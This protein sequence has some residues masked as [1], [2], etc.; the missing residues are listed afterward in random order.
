MDNKKNEVFF[1]TKKLTKKF[2]EV[3]AVNQV[4][5][6]IRTGEIRGLIGENGSGKSTIS[7]MISAIHT[8]TDGEMLLYGKPYKPK[9]PG[10]ARA[11]G[12]TMIVQEM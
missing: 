5:M 12:I 2:G 4:D 11:H 8:V 3:V 6:V 1:E 9:D 10:D 7:S